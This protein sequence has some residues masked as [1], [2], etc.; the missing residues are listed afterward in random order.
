MSISITS[1][2]IVHTGTEGSHSWMIVAPATASMASTMAQNHQYS[3]P[4]VKPAHGP[5]AGRVYSTKEPFGGLATAISRSM[6][7]TSST[8]A[9]AAR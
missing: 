3:Q 5:I 2:E 4:V 8:S 9:P 7:I 6:R 1:R